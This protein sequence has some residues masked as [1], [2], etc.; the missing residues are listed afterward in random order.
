MGMDVYGINPKMKDDA[1][2]PNMPDFKSLNDQEKQA[3]FDAVEKFEAENPGVYFRANVWWWRPLWQYTCDLM[4]TEFND[5]DIAGGSVNAGYA[6]TED[7]ALVLSARLQTAIESNAH[8]MYERDYKIM[9][10]NLPQVE[11]DICE[12]VGMRQYERDENITELAPCNACQ[13]TKLKDDF[14]TMYPFSAE[15]VEEFAE[16]VKNSGGFE[17][18]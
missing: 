17:V 12:G 1:K 13:G 9:Q 3:Y 14:R 7:K 11:C 4:D 6:I 15:T 5:E 2:K 8:H 18:R 10:D 16:F